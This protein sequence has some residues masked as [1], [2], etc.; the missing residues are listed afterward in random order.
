MR[1]NLNGEAKG[2]IVHE[3]VHV[4]QQYGRARRAVA[5]AE[6]LGVLE[7]LVAGSDLPNTSSL[8]VMAR[9]GMT[10]A[11]ERR[12]GKLPVRYYRIRRETFAATALQ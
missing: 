2:A 6:D 1:Q 12:V 7:E 3:L 8:R 5:M 10:F 9:L 11:G 4:V